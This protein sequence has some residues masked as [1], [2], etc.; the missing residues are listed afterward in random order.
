MPENNLSDVIISSLSGIKEF[1][2]AETIIGDPIH[3]KSG[4][5]IIPVSKVSMGFAT[6]GLD[7]AK[8]DNPHR[9]KNFGGGGG[10]GVSITPIAFLISDGNGKVDLLPVVSPQNIGT[11]DK[12]ASLIERSPE[13][14][15]ELKEVLTPERVKDTRI[16]KEAVR[17]ARAEKEK[18]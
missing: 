1:A 6:G 2:G 13:I 5:D 8:H 18:I 3:L 12:I 15:G 14:L 17:A 7:Y 9:P 16:R 4:S 10:T 11:V